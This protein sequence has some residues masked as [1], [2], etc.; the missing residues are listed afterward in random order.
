MP[1]SPSPSPSPQ[2]SF[3][4][5]DVEGVCTI[6][7]TRHH[8]EPE[9][10]DELYTM[11]TEAVAGGTT[12]VVLNLIHV[13]TMKSATIAI[14][15]TLQKRVRAD[16]G[17]LKLCRVRPDTLRLLQIAHADSLFEIHHTQREAVAAFLGRLEPEP[18]KADKRWF[19]KLHW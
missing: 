5:E 17:R 7:V 13:E 4:R 11:A 8:L 15:L 12:Q 19:P 3:H 18:E 1:S 9:V 14:L 2:K 16:G 10:S 6:L